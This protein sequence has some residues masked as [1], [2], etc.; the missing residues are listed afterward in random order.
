MLQLKQT[1]SAL[2]LCPFVL[3]VSL[4]DG[5]RPAHVALGEGGS[6]LLRLP[7]QLLISPKHPHIP[8]PNSRFTSCLESLRPVQMT[9]QTNH[10]ALLEMKAPSPCKKV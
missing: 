5:L 7:A 10:H 6:A 1:E 8:T 9:R 4:V 2:F 3:F